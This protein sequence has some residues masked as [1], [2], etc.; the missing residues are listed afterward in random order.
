M[1]PI[2]SPESLVIWVSFC[3]FRKKLSRKCSFKIPPFNVGISYSITCYSKKTKERKIP[4]ISGISHNKNIVLAHT[5]D[6]D[7]QWVAFQLVIQASRSLPSCGSS[8]FGVSWFSFAILLPAGRPRRGE[9]W[10]IMEKLL[11]SGPQVACRCFP[12]SQSHGH[13]PP[14]GR[15]KKEYFRYNE[16]NNN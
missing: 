4:S 3:S 11:W 16:K 9:L 6:V 5:T 15:K 8:S 12:R 2:T 10:E 1:L 14:H 13:I 7:V